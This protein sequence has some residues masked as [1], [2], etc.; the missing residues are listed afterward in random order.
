MSSLRDP[1]LGEVT[2]L[3]T[4]AVAIDFKTTREKVQDALVQDEAPSTEPQQPK[5]LGAERIAS[6]RAI[7]EQRVAKEQDEWSAL[8]RKIAEWSEVISAGDGGGPSDLRATPPP[9]AVSSLSLPVAPVGLHQENP[10][11]QSSTEKEKRRG[12]MSAL[13][14]RCDTYSLSGLSRLN[15]GLT[16]LVRMTFPVGLL[17]A[18]PTFCALR[19][20]LPGRQ[21]SRGCGAYSLF[22]RLSQFFVYAHEKGYLAGNPFKP[23]MM[24]IA[25]LIATTRHEQGQSF[26]L[27]WEAWLPLFFF[28][29]SQIAIA[30]EFEPDSPEQVEM[31]R[32]KTQFG[33]DCL[34]AA[35]GIHDKDVRTART[36]SSVGLKE[37]ELTLL[38]ENK[39]RTIWVPAEKVRVIRAA[40]ALCRSNDH[41]WVPLLFLSAYVY[42]LNSGSLFHMMGVA[43]VIYIAKFV[44][45][46]WRRVKFNRIARHF[47]T[48]DDEDDARKTS[49]S[50][51][52]L[53]ELLKL[54]IDTFPR[55]ECDTLLLDA[56]GR[57]YF[58][59]LQAV[60]LTQSRGSKARELLNETWAAFRLYQAAPLDR[61][62]FRRMD[63]VEAMNKD[64]HVRSQKDRDL[65]K[66]FGFGQYRQ[67]WRQKAIPVLVLAKQLL[68]GVPYPRRG[69]ER[70]CHILSLPATIF[71]RSVMVVVI[72][73]LLYFSPSVLEDGFG[74]TDEKCELWDSTKDCDPQ[75]LYVHCVWLYAMWPSLIG[76][77]RR[78]DDFK[79]LAEMV[80][81]MHINL[82]TMISEEVSPES[83]GL[84][85]VGVSD[86][87]GLLLWAQCREFVLSSVIRRMGAYELMLGWVVLVYLSI[88][89]I[90]VVHFVQHLDAFTSLQGYSDVLVQGSMFRKWGAHIWCANG[91]PTF[92]A[93]LG[94]LMVFSGSFM[95]LTSVFFV[96]VMVVGMRIN[97]MLKEQVTYVR[98]FELECAS[99]I[100]LLALGVRIENEHGIGDVR[101]E[102][103]EEVR[104]I[105]RSLA[106]FMQMDGGQVFRVLGFTMTGTQ[107]AGLLMG[108][109]AGILK[110]LMHTESRS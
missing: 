1:L 63:V 41:L 76:T 109:V 103:V 95:L 53:Y 79:R 37:A 60:G 86:A 26:V 44:V 55:S 20:K 56:Q 51:V 65:R 91:S 92:C 50:K 61:A 14:F 101:K 27:L 4:S 11:A 12:F 73:L 24:Y 10:V 75:V 52:S 84:P 99:C 22:P 59:N 88:L 58:A 70:C 78:F 69:V 3:P 30:V 83:I 16:V 43:A 19:Q 13:L 5:V 100:G 25:I 39:L 67:A 48:I 40:C 74:L 89:L 57:F 29:C 90:L 45:C 85:A 32:K 80:L 97:R 87:W 49:E 62:F 82:N 8:E 47:E 7:W 94:L 54:L 36:L 9:T 34:A 35:L 81:D 6:E 66:E 46:Q 15:V 110:L 31:W 28:V 77:I 107:I 42:R 106:D 108:S 102:E 17:F 64:L 71:F 21:D 105:A 98:S 68:I 38:L 93:S 23:L 96:P 33:A 72:I 18:V 2:T 104:D